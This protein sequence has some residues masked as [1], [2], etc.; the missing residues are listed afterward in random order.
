MLKDLQIYQ[1]I[2]DLILYSFPILNRFPKSQRFVLA[3]QIENQMLELE[4]LVIQANAERDKRRSLFR[5]DVEL[6]KLRV[7]V[8][9]AHDLKFMDMRRYALISERLVEI[10]KLL[11]GWIKKCNQQKNTGLGL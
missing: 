5:L 10:G 6:E 9:L 4:K 1:K 7:L 11:G 3:Q 2:Y 8:R